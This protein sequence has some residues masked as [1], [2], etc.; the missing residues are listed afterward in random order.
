MT[1]KRYSL[2]VF[3]LMLTTS[4][5]VYATPSISIQEIDHTQMNR[6]IF[7]EDETNL[8]TWLPEKDNKLKFLVTVTEPPSKV[9]IEFDFTEV[10]NWPGYCM[11][12]DDGYGI[13]QDLC[14]YEEDQDKNNSDGYKAYATVADALNG[15]MLPITEYRVEGGT[16]NGFVPLTSCPSGEEDHLIYSFKSSNTI[17]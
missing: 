12:A 11:N 6:R 16:R 7:S 4:S 1:M 15:N 14:I 3:V 8:D 5:F 13:K 17:S 2:I 10:S 9:K